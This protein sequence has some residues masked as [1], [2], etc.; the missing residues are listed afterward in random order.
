M[1]SGHNFL[2]AEK[3][4]FFLKNRSLQD[5]L[6]ALL[7]ES[8]RVIKAHSHTE[9]GIRSERWNY[10][11]L[12]HF[13]LLEANPESAAWTWTPLSPARNSYQPINGENYFHSAT[14][15]PPQD[16]SQRI[17]QR[18]SCPVS[19]SWPSFSDTLCWLIARTAILRSAMQHPLLTHWKFFTAVFMT[20]EFFFSN[21]EVILEQCHNPQTN[22]KKFRYII[23]TK[24]NVILLRK[25]NCLSF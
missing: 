23:F 6:Q 21:Y 5:L 12:G 20:P 10:L 13:H 17:L 9:F 3:V 14:K 16:R 19:P 4:L 15:S 7:W 11:P 24:S 1:D 2:K 18:S 22:P 8:I 25:Q